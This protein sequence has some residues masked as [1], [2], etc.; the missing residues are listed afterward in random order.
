M[1]NRGHQLIHADALA[2]ELEALGLDSSIFGAAGIPAPVF[3][4]LLP[5]R[6]GVWDALPNT[7]GYGDFSSAFTRASEALYRDGSGIWRSAGNGIL[8]P[9]HDASGNFLGVLLEPESINKCTNYNANP[10]A[11]LSNIT[12]SG[13]AAATLTRVDDTAAL[14][15]AGLQAVCSSGFV[16][17]L[18]NS[19]GSTNA[20][21]EVTGA[22]GNTNAHSCSVMWR[23]SGTGSVGLN[24]GAPA[25]QPLPSGYE[26]FKAPD[27]TPLSAGNFWTLFANAGAVIYFVLNQVEEHVVVTSPIT[28]VGSTSTRSADDLSWPLADWQGNDFLN[29]AAGMGAIIWRPGFSNTDLPNNTKQTIVSGLNNST[30]S[31]LI[32]ARTDTGGNPFFWTHDSTSICELAKAWSADTDYLIP[33]RWNATANEKQIGVKTAGSWTWATATAYDGSQPNDSVLNVASTPI[34]GP[35]HHRGMFLWDQDDDTDV[36]E[37]IFAEMVN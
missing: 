20:L 17:K 2:A 3:A 32:S 16:F 8:R 11:A 10:D 22:V 34:V 9:D 12:K 7:H 23:G 4:N 19:A 14:A 26:R 25:A 1:A 27:R 36:I 24:T 15:A 18:D 6:A 37:K 30:T 31:A 28:T 33:V 35:A 13:D 29:D 21:A 5:R